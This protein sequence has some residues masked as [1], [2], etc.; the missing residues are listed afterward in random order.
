MEKL[1][2]FLIDVF[3]T[4]LP[5]RLRKNIDYALENILF[6]EGRQKK[7]QKIIGSDQLELEKSISNGDSA[8][9]AFA[10]HILIATCKRSQQK[11]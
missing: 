3:Y 4:Q 9:A 11:T 7:F 8:S 6:M 5:N 10:A 2:K 1:K